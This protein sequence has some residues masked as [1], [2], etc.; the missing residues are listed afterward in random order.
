MGFPDRWPA[1][2]VSPGRGLPADCWN[3][4]VYKLSFEKSPDFFVHGCAL[5]FRMSLASSPE[6]FRNLH[7]RSRPAI[8]LT[9]GRPSER[10]CR[11]R[12][13]LSGASCD[14]C[15]AM[16]V[17]EALDAWEDV[18]S[19]IVA[20][21]PKAHIGQKPMIIADSADLEPPRSH[22]VRPPPR[23][24]GTPPSDLPPCRSFGPGWMY[25]RRIPPCGFG[26]G[27]IS[28]DADDGA[29]GIGRGTGGERL[30]GSDSLT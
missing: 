13:S 5:R 9:A 19:P 16:M 1:A 7:H 15:S 8:G 23:R 11:R 2:A 10:P 24:P 30:L 22:A 12:R 3:V 25:V 27:W 29:E 26:R 21:E 6:Y 17:R 20:V 18:K 28:H 4:S 14:R